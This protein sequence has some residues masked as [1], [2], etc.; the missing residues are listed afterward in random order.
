M[1]WIS[2]KCCTAALICFGAGAVAQIPDRPSRPSPYFE[3]RKQ[4][5]EYAGPGREDPAPGEVQEV[6]LGY[7]GP[8][9]PSHPDGGDLWSAAG[10]A[11]EEANRQGG[12]QGKPLR[13][14]ASWS[15]NP[16]GSGVSQV[17]RM[18]YDDKVWAIV[19]GIDGPS[20]HLAEQVVAKA[21]LALISPASSDKTANLANVPWLFSCLP[22]DHLQAPVLAAAIADRVGRAPLVLVSTTDH[23]SHLFAQELNKSLTKHRLLPHYHFQCEPQTPQLADLAARVVKAEPAAV[24]LIAGAHDSARLITALRQ[25]GFSGIV[26]GSASMGRRR[27]Q[28]EAGEAAEGVFFPLLYVPQETNDEFVK[29]FQARFNRSPDYAAAHT[30]DAVRLLVAA[31]RKAGLNRARIR[32]AVEEL[33]PWKGVT[34]SVSWDP[35]GSNTRSVRL[36]T[37][38]DGLAVPVGGKQRQGVPSAARCR[39]SRRSLCRS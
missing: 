27:F 37:I 5:A 20:T 12:C 36:G 1:P 25:R 39:S 15:E 19:G 33:S 32:D 13:L 7:F 17:V 30:Y 3:L 4:Q 14:V 24:A 23:D 11:V 9:D 16:W 18:A 34:G 35:L 38:Q 22:G 2:V 26:F 8:S 6:L 29:T 21:R 10:L 31:I 28:Q